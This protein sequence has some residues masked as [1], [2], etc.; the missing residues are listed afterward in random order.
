[1]QMEDNAQPITIGD[2]MQ[3]TGASEYSVRR[4]LDRLGIE[5][6]APIN[7]RRRIEYPPGTL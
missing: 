1:M 5:G 7:D 2:L 6:R 4:A 3:E